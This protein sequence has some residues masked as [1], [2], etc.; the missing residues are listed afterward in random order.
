MKKRL[1]TL[2]ACIAAFAWMGLFTTGCN[3]TEGVGEDIEELGDNI[4]DSVS[5]DD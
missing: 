5:D 2:I 3:T 4:D 1:A